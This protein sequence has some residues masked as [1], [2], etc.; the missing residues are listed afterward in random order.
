MRLENITVGNII[1]AIEIYMKIA[2]MDEKPLHQPPEF[3]ADCDV[4]I[5]ENL[6]RFE[7]EP[8]RKGEER[9]HRYILRLGNKQYPFMKLVLQEHLVEDDY[10]LLVD[11]HDE[12][13]A[14]PSP[15]FDALLKIRNFNQ[16]V[17]DSIETIWTESEL[18]TLYNLQQS[19]KDRLE[20]NEGYVG[21]RI[22]VVDDDRVMGESMCSL[23]EAKGFSVD[24]RYDGIEA[25]RDAERHRHDLIVMDNEM[26]IM[27][28]VEAC[29]II[30]Q[31]PL[32]GDIP[33]MIVSAGNIDLP[34]IEIADA[35]L[36]KPFHMNTLFQ[37]IDHHLKSD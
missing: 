16:E 33:I 9:L 36:S 2:Y 8:A 3:D 31:D 6:N 30:K 15:D 12:M 29:R 10:I 32:R 20:V 1:Q 23:L 26:K 11:T 19:F 25:V 35:A 17:K 21:R 7:Q 5:R 24:R 34:D 13:F 18:P 22:L 14:M 4:S 37:F 28:G 27:D